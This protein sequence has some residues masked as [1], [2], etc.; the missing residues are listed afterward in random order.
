MVPSRRTEPCTARCSPADADGPPTERSTLTPPPRGAEVNSC[1]LALGMLHAWCLRAGRSPAPHG[2]TRRTPMADP[3]SG[4]PSRPLRAGPKLTAV[5]S[6][7]R[8][9]GV[10]PACCILRGATPGS[11][12]SWFGCFLRLRRATD[13]PVAG[14]PRMELTAVNLRSQ[15]AEVPSRPALRKLPW[16]GRTPRGAERRM[17]PVPTPGHPRR[18]AAG[19]GAGVDS[20][21][22]AVAVRAAGHRRGDM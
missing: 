7:L 17:P 16:R 14:S 12:A 18:H 2:V 6:H 5:N 8:C 10:R 20:C 19:W 3:P 11:D 4:L 9:P 15:R 22:L 21:Q 1:Q 13:G